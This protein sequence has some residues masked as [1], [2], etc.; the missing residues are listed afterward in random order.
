MQ[1]ISGGKHVV[2]TRHTE[3]ACYIR[4]GAVFALGMLVAAA[5]VVVVR[6][7]AGALGSPLGSAAL[8]TTGALIAGV[9]VAIRL[10]WLLAPGARRHDRGVMLV[11]GLCVMALGASLSVPGT[12]GIARL[13]LFALLAIEEGCT[14]AWYLGRVT[15]N[16]SALDSTCGAGCQPA[17]GHEQV[18]TLLHRQIAHP[19]QD[20]VP[21]NEVVQQLTRSRAADGVE[22]LAGWLRIPFAAGQRTGSVHVAFCPPLAATPELSVEQ[23]GGPPSRVKTAQLL[24][25]GVRLDL[26]LAAAAEEPTS[27]LLQF[28]AR[29]G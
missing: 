8:L 21:P 3:C 22:S 6:R 19:P 1:E 14:W 2:S 26:K 20:D 12:P 5:L 28:T 29:S 23:I 4:R 9:A 10:A 16:Q 24:P 7:W 15:D 17:S 18:G 11:T 27:V 25:Y 13:C